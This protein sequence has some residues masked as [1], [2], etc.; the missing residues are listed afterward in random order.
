MPDLLRY[1]RNL[2]SPEEGRYVEQ[3]AAWY[4]ADPPIKPLELP[5]VKPLKGERDRDR[6]WKRLKRA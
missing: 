3:L 5:A 1:V 2:V 6:L 4:E